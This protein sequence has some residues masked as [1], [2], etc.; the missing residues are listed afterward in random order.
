[1]TA[2]PVAARV[3]PRTI[4]DRCTRAGALADLSMT[5]P[6]D[7]GEMKQKGLNA[8]QQMRAQQIAHLGSELSRGAAK[9]DSA[10]NRPRGRASVR[11]PRPVSLER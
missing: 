9:M 11:K 8:Y 6:L 2:S 3:M 5:V 1:M 4:A 10:A 7:D